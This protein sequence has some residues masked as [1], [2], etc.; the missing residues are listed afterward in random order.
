MQLPRLVECNPM[1]AVEVFLLKIHSAQIT[2]YFSVLLRMDLSVHSMEVV[3][4]LTIV[5]GVGNVMPENKIVGAVSGRVG[6]VS[7]SV[8]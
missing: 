1:I 4:R 2:D 7:A 5:S 6:N 3:N 8:R